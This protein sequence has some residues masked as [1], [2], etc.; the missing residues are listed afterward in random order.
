MTVADQVLAA[1]EKYAWPE[2]VEF[3]GG[4]FKT[5]K[6]GY[7]EGDMFIGVRVPPTRQVA[8]EFKDISLDD[9]E[10]ILE[11]PIHEMRLCAV[12]IMTLQ[13]KKAS[14]AELK[15]LV[16]LYLRRTDRI[17]NWDIVDVSCRYIVGS[18]ILKHP[19]DST[20]L[21]RLARSNDLWEKRI[22]MVST[23]TLIRAGELDVAYLIA[24]RLLTDKHD[25]IHKAVGWMLRDMGDKDRER[26]GIFLSAHIREIPRTA[27]R[28]A[29]EHMSPEERQYYLKLR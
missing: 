22:A 2:A 27:L 9:I 18:W 16:D 29:I 3:L 11:S 17:N 7:G 20:I 23:W 26:L 15:A 21:T 5:H 12:I 1:L 25:L 24:E 6:S 13:A 10:K 4:F 14:D 28:Y 19:E 8:R